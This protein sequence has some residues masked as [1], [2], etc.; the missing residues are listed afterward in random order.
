MQCH[1]P[2]PGHG[3]PSLKFNK[4]WLANA[5]SPT[6]CMSLQTLTLT[7]NVH[8]NTLRHHLQINGLMKQFSDI[9]D[10]ELD[11][12]VCHY[13]LGHPNAGLRFILASLKSHGLSIQ[14]EHVWKSMQQID[15]LS[16]VICIKQQYSIVYMKP[17]NQITSGTLMVTTNL[18]SRALL[19][20]EWLMGIVKQ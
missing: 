1:L 6:H 8:Q 16:H 13:K 17:H 20:M 4:E 3:H 11:V 19:F 9:T 5:M 18:Y 7:L 2:G 14:Q 15:P 12:L 10:V